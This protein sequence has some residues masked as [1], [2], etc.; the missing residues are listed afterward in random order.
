MAPPAI[1]G[2]GALTHPQLATIHRALLEAYVAIDA[3]AAAAA[4]CEAWKSNDPGAVL[5][6]VRVSPKIR[7]ACEAP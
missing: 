6:P 3:R 1:R 4:A 5:D 7:A 2:G